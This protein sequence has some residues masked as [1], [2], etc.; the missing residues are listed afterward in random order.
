IPQNP[1]VIALRRRA[2]NNLLKLRTC[3]NIAGFLRQIDPYGVPIGIGSGMVSP[4]GTIFSGIVEAPPTPYRYA[5]LMARAKELV[6]IAQQI[7]AGYQT[8]LERAEVA[9][10]DV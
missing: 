3:R 8:A 4:D 6:N 1:V 9:A 7:E 5:A 2:E 10:G